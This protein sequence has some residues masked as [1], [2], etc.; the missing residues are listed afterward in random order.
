MIKLRFPPVPYQCRTAI[1]RVDPAG[2]RAEVNWGNHTT[3]INRIN[4]PKN[5]I[6]FMTA[7]SFVVMLF[8]CRFSY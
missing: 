8:L 4:D 7:T 2:S 3:I 6:S 1:L 5:M